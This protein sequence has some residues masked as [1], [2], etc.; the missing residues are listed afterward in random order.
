M[1]K[2]II[3][4]LLHPSEPNITQRASKPNENRRIVEIMFDVIV[5]LFQRSLHVSF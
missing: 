4:V 3:E 5:A 2:I 1:N